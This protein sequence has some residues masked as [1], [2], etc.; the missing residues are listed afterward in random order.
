MPRR[1]TPQGQP[2]FRWIWHAFFRTAL[3]PLLLVEVVLILA[4]LGA[5]R[6][7]QREN[8]AAIRTVASEELSRIATR[9]AAFLDQQLSAATVGVKVLADEVGRSLD[10]PLGLS[11][12]ERTAALERYAVAPEGLYYRTRDEGGSALFYSSRTKID[13]AERE[14]V[15]KTERLDPLLRSIVRNN[16]LWVQAYLNT[17]DSMNRI[18]PFMDVRKQY[19]PDMDIPSYNFYYEADAKHNPTREVVWTDVYVD[20]AGQG[21][22]ASCIAP[23]YRGEALEGVV[24]ADVTVATLVAQVLGLRIPWEGYGVL[25]GRTGT[26]LALPRGGERDFALTELTEH[27]YQAAILKDTFKPDAFNLYKRKDVG[28]LSGA[29]ERQREGL[30]EGALS[31]EAKRVAW[32]TVDA[33]GWK[34]VV[35]VPQAR[36]DG[37]AVTLGERIG[38]IALYMVGGLV[39][40]YICFFVYL[41]RKART[42]SRGIADPLTRINDLVRN[43][44]EGHY[45]QEAVPVAVVELDETAR[46]V[47][48]MGRRLGE[49]NAALLRTQDELRAAKEQAESAARAKSE[50]LARMSHEIRTPMNGVLG[51]TELLLETSLAPVQKEYAGIIQGSA[52]G[53]LSIINDILDFSKMEAGKMEL[54]REPFELDTLLE[55]TLDM[56]AQRA[57]DKHVELVL[58]LPDEVPRDLAGDPGRLRQV[59]VN[60]L[61]NAVKFTDAGEAVTSVSVAAEDTRSVLLRFEVKDTGVGIAPG[62]HDRIFDAFAQADGSSTRRHGGTGLGLAISRQLVRL[63]GGEL[64]LSSEQGR[65]STFWF[66]AR[67]EKAPPRASRAATKPNVAGLCALVVDDSPA[68]RAALCATLTGLGMKAD[69]ADGGGAAMNLLHQAASAGRPYDVL[70]VDRDMPGMSGCDVVDAALSSPKTASIAFILLLPVG[71]EAPPLPPGARAARIHKPVHRSALTAALSAVAGPR[72]AIHDEAPRS[73]KPVDS[74]AHAGLRVLLAEDNLVNQKVAQKMLAT[75]GCVVTTV[76][77]G[78]AAVEAFERGSYRLV[79]MDCQMP[80][81]D[82]YRATEE[83]RRREEARG[84]SRTPIVALTANAMAQDRERALSAGMDDHLAKPIERADLQRMLVRHVALSRDAAGAPRGVSASEDAGP[85]LDARMV[86]GLRELGALEEIG[87]AFL[88]E[89]PGRM[90]GLREASKKR[91]VVDLERRAHA[92]KGSSGA[93]GAKRVAETSARLE[94]LARSG[95]IDGAEELITRLE[96]EFEDFARA[97]EDEW[98]RDAAGP[99]A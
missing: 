93:V 29:V 87:R 12:A 95:A 10:E 49:D 4:Y 17:S 1:T 25:I 52:K 61:G 68:S 24:G 83:I 76:D 73:E 43:I 8:T 34:L 92:L 66:T 94:S 79:L 53:L 41:Y 85:V 3:I 58:R 23:V 88:A 7:V 67:L 99:G 22:M 55:G 37:Q 35:I 54:A 32:S 14:K 38:R 44:G 77:N 15:L 56:L 48:G 89:V 19:P 42:M 20:P 9:E 96:R 65:G 71:R 33:T 91:D 78:R 13:D 57:H 16:P 30:F 90:V 47:V 21:W 5:N 82:G 98:S 63:F 59:L 50:F 2:L 46:G 81:M 26:I 6:F 39:V 31:G 28:E 86:E 11:D 40:F 45:A 69:E 60:L 70:L 80:E 18:Y 84:L 72:A 64:G 27:D 36:I 97:I 51:M 62:D 75:L 74:G